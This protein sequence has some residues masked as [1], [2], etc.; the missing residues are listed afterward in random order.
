MPGW[1]IGFIGLSNPHASAYL[2][3]LRE[4]PATV[5]GAVDLTDGYTSEEKHGLDAVPVYERIEELLEN[6]GLDAVWMSLSNRDTPQAIE[7]AA[8]YG[9][10]VYAE[11]TL[12]RTS[13]DLKPVLRVVDDAGIT[14]VAGYQNRANPVVRKIR[15]LAAADFFGN[16]RAIETRMITSRINPFRDPTSFVYDAEMSRG[17]IL[18]WLG[19]H[20]ID[21]IG[22][23]LEEP[24]K[25]VNAQIAYGTPNVD[26]EDGAT[27]QFELSQSN[28]FGTLQAG[29]YGREYD[30]YI[31]LYGSQGRATWAWNE[32]PADRDILEV[33]NYSDRWSVAPTRKLEFEYDGTPG[34]GGSIG[35]E[36]M[37]NFL[38]SIS[39]QNADPE[40]NATIRDSYLTLQT[41]DA[42]YESAERD[43][44]VAVD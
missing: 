11:K 12:A 1:K 4:L 42:M 35:L 33:E 23:M 7:L 24:I 32:T 26:V 15:S 27:V 6:E 13:V 38:E 22:Y 9:I 28:A 18:Q 40:L 44:W 5:V 10:D 17:G 25:R 30:T 36:Y 34:Y 3:S 31:S 43:E 41:L 29:Y 16:L 20:T 19:C 14:V 2:E 21:L 37:R 39:G 8:E